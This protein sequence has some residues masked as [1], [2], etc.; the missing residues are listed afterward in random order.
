MYYKRFIN[1]ENGGGL[2]ASK[3]ICSSVTVIKTSVMITCLDKDAQLSHCS[4]C[5]SESSSLRRCSQCKQIK[6]CSEKCQRLSW[7]IHKLECSYL[8]QIPSLSNVPPLIRLC[9]LFVNASDLKNDFAINDLMGND[10]MEN[11]KIHEYYPFVLQGVTDLLKGV[12]VTVNPTDIYEIYCKLVVNLFTLENGQL[13]DIGT[14]LIPEISKINHSCDPNCVISFEG[15]NAFITAIKD[16]KQ[17]SEITI[18]YIPLP[19]SLLKR[20]V[21][22]KLQYYFSCQCPLCRKQKEEKIDQMHMLECP[23]CK[24]CTNPKINILNNDLT[25][26]TCSGSL[27]KSIKPNDLSLTSSYIPSE[28]QKDVDIVNFLIE[29]TENLILDKKWES[30]LD[31][32]LK[33]VPGLM[34]WACD[35]P[36]TGL[37]LAKLGKLY[38][39]QESTDLLTPKN[40]VIEALC[41]FEISL[42]CLSLSLSKSHELKIEVENLYKNTLHILEFQ[43]VNH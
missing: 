40:D 39:E 32:G 21:Q 27:L 37:F 25:C 35:Y 38:L 4:Q 9:S 16:I 23:I 33:A 30:A 24:N 18:S 41:L 1:E 13:K 6:Y 31:T 5:L 10:V 36:S 20:N 15:P 22:L 19:M 28:C 11:D 26:P 17:D 29:K 7:K 3:K 14:V 34:E 8:H 43:N 2:F 42:K 12:S